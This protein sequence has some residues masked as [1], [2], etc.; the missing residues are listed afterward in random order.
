[1]YSLRA[2]LND[3]RE[4]RPKLTRR[5]F[6]EVVRE[7]RY[8]LDI[9]REEQNMRLR[10]A[11]GK[12]VWGDM[13]LSHSELSHDHFDFLS[14]TTPLNR[15]DTDIIRTEI[16]EQIDQKLTLLDRIGEH[17]SSHV[18]HSGNS[19]SRNSK[20][21]DA[22]N[23]SD[24]RDTLKTLKE[25]SDLVGV[26]F[27]NQSGAGLAKYIGD[28]FQGLDAALVRHEDMDDLARNWRVIDCDI[29]TWVLNPNDL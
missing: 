28:Q 2:V 19:Q 7:C 29:D 18:A 24:A 3:V 14:G 12:A 23:I 4:C 13:A 16:F 20:Q 26:W 15:T 22:F 11:N 17:V 5:V 10:A 8:D 21:L 27:A 6:V 9:L 1:M 25:L